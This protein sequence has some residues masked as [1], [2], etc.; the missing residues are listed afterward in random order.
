MKE[1]LLFLFSFTVF[2]FILLGTIFILIFPFG[3]FHPVLD[4]STK[5]FELGTVE[6]SSVINCRFEIQ[7]KGNMPLY[8][9]GMKSACGSGNDIKGI[10][11]SNEPLEPKKQRE[12]S[13]LFY[14]RFLKGE[15][16]KK[17][18]IQSNDPQ[19]PYFILTVHANVI[20]VSLPDS[21]SKPTLAPLV[22]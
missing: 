21:Q 11:F 18:V 3:L 2:L 1:F 16:T 17:V 19:H 4:C 5:N 10:S 9:N 13:F 22:D 15:S 12:C 20:P 6:S 8:F 7:N 14:P